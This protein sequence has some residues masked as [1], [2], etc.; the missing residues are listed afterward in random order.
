LTAKG[1]NLPVAS[2]DLGDDWT[3]A[4]A[5][6]V[7]YVMANIH[8]FF[9]GVTAEEAA[10]WTWSFWQ[11][12]DVPLKADKSKHI[13]SETGWPSAGGTNCGAA[14][15]CPVGSVAGI[16]E[17]NTF[18]DGWVCQALTNSTNYFLFE[19]FDE[20]WKIKFNEPGKEWED[21][22]GIMDVNRNLKPGL[23]IPACDG[24]TV[25]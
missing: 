23:V 21:K 17:M 11:N 12:K 3:Q 25:D 22:W 8:P 1:I 18:L 15:T 14:V 19:A 20:P 7:D 24:R 9:A 2:S 10:G 6:E 4:L 16:D 13:I 5:D